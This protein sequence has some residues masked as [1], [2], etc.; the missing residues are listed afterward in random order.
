VSDFA[1]NNRGILF[2]AQNNDFFIHTIDD[3]E[4]RE[5]GNQLNSMLNL[6]F[7]MQNSLINSALANSPNHRHQDTSFNTFRYSDNHVLGYL[8]SGFT[9]NKYYNDDE[10]DI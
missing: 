9:V 2:G 8:N 10:E 3:Q 4:D 7:N 1:E 6:N 5:E